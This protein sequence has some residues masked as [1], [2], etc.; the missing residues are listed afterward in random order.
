MSERMGPANHPPATPATL[1]L[2]EPG[3]IHLWRADLDAIEPDLAC[4]N[5]EERARAARFRTAELTHR[6]AAGRTRLRQ[7]LARYLG[8]TP[9][10]VKFSYNPFG[11]PELAHAPPGSNLDFNLSHT[12]NHF[13]LAV[14]RGRV[15]VDIELS[16][17]E[18]DLTGL[19]RQ[20]M[21]PDELRTF[22]ALP[23]PERTAA[24]FALWTAKEAIIKVLGTGFSRDARTL[25]I[26]WTEPL[27]LTDAGRTYRVRRVDYAPGVPAA[28]ALEGVVENIRETQS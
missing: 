14:A 7:V 26:G 21:S 2:P 9:A 19:A 4:L 6:F 11:R 23:D 15:G 16:T 13:L 5:D 24:F 12:E 10:K 25:Q 28:V 17:R 22:E 8:C 20:V 1:T 3:D 27:S 18:T